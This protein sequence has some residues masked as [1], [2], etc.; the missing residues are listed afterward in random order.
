MLGRGSDRSTWSGRE[1]MHIRWAGKSEGRY[2]SSST[3]WTKG[4]AYLDTQVPRMEQG[5]AS[6]AVKEAC[7]T[8]CIEWNGI[9]DPCCPLLCDT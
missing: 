3:A 1:L 8:Q 5:E 4:Q 6:T 2:S 7:I 9:I